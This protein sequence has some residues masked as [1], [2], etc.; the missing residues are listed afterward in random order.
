MHRMQLLSRA[1][2]A[3]CV[4]WAM[5]WPI[6]TTTV[7]RIDCDCTNA[8]LE[9]DVLA[10]CMATIPEIDDTAELSFYNVASNGSVAASTSANVVRNIVLLK[11]CTAHNNS[12]IPT[13]LLNAFGGLSG[14]DLSIGLQQIP[15]ARLP[16]KLK[17]L[18]LG[19]NRIGSIERDA[20][21]AAAGELEHINLQHNQIDAITANGAFNGLAKLNTLILYRNRLTALRSGVFSGA[22]SL[23]YLDVASNEIA[24][25]D[26]DALALA[27]LKEVLIS[28]NRLHRLSDNVFRLAPNVHNVDMQK[29]RLERIGKAF[30]G[31]RHLQQLLLSENHHLEDI[32]VVA[33]SALP[34][35]ISLSIDATGMRTLYEANASVTTPSVSPLHTLS[36]SQNHFGG[37]DFLRQLAIFPRLQNLF[38]DANKFTRWLEGD[39]RSI[40]TLFPHIELIVTKNN[41]W[42]RQWVESTLIPVFQANNIFCSNVKYLNTYIEGFTN[43]VDGQI[44][45]STEC[46]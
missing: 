2:V 23:E 39:V 16:G 13:A 7:V 18:N 36:V 46:I 4:L 28:D 26:D 30:A 8:S 5:C 27:R 24:T 35:L 33:L 15:T 38:V 1:I 32:D 45:E 43:S 41:A 21:G 11:I 3:F 40:K 12:D 6:A 25:I 34:E 10:C 19:R 37:A 20:F 17:Q 29:N 44:I 42:D 14:L 31:T 22:E 9:T